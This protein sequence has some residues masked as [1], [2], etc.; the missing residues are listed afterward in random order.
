[1]VLRS[2]DMVP[3]PADPKPLVIGNGM[4]APY[5]VGTL[6][7]GLVVVGLPPESKRL[8]FCRRFVLMLVMPAVVVAKADVVWSVMVSEATKRPTMSMRV[9]GLTAVVNWTVPR[10]PEVAPT[11]MSPA[12]NEEPVKP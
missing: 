7:K 1:M 10:A 8:N 2:A 6:W 12:L 4:G 9:T 11:M 5:G 3:S